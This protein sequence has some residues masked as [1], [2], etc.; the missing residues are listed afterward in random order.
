[1]FSTIKKLVELLDEDEKRVDFGGEI[2]PSAIEKLNVQAY[3]LN[4]TGKTLERFA[5]FMMLIST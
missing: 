2:I 1:M 5:R 3:F 4:N